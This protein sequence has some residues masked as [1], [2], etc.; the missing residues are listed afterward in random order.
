M[1]FKE[2]LGMNEKVATMKD[3]KRV[4]YGVDGEVPA[5]DIDG[6]F[7]T[8]FESLELQHLGMGVEGNN[9]IIN[10]YP[11]DQFS[12]RELKQMIGKSKGTVT[13]S[14]GDE[15]EII[16]NYKKAKNFDLQSVVQGFSQQGFEF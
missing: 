12:T 14:D 5:A 11:L 8:S 15:F 6:W 7:G 2:Y 13:V 16:I 9:I 3:L 10:A 4:L 1:N